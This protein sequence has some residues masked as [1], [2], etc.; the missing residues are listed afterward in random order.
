LVETMAKKRDTTSEILAKRDRLYRRRSVEQQITE[1][2]KSLQSA[3]SAIHKTDKAAREELLRYFPIGLV[4]VIEFFFRNTV[5]GFL[6]EGAAGI[7]L[8][9]KFVEKVEIE[10]AFDIERGK[11]TTGDYVAH[12]IPLNNLDD[13]NV[14]MSAILEKDFLGEIKKQQHAGIQVF[15]DEHV[16]AVI[17][18]FEVRHIFCHELASKHQIKAGEVTDFMGSVR[19]FLAATE[20]YIYGEDY[21]GFL[22][23]G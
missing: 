13:V 11:I 15:G 19:R 22:P 18:L 9:R 10:T 1:R 21:S 4:A 2:I 7:G 23:A 14:A 6:D 5:R 12:R 20:M 16:K 17:A 3:F 8:V